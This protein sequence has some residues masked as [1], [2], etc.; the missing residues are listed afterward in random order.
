MYIQFFQQSGKFDAIIDFIFLKVIKR[1]TN[2]HKGIQR[3]YTKMVVKVIKTKCFTV[4]WMDEKCVMCLIRAE[5]LCYLSYGLSPTIVYIFQ[6]YKRPIDKDNHYCKLCLKQITMRLLLQA[7]FKTNTSLILLK[8]C[9]E[10]SE[11][12]TSS[13]IKWSTSE[14]LMYHLSKLCMIRDMCMSCYD[15]IDKSND[16]SGNRFRVIRVYKD[17]TNFWKNK[18]CH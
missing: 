1:F 10:M 17:A 8:N 14:F 4:I 11:Y 5:Q 16:R 2:G 13:S 15:H 3:S 7:F 6:S 12:L 18:R 9:I